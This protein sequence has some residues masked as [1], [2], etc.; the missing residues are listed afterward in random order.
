MSVAAP[1]V[2]TQAP[3]PGVPLGGA[4]RLAE[5]LL[6]IPAVAVGA[7]AV[8][9]VD[10]ADTGQL[11]DGFWMWVA[12]GAA[13]ALVAHLA[14]RLLAPYSDPVLLPVTVALNGLGLAL[15][16][17]LDVAADERAKARGSAA[18]LSFAE[19]Q[20]VWSALG[21]VLFIGV[22]VVVRELRTLAR[23][24]YTAMLVGLVLLLLPLAP[25]I[26][27]N[28]NGARIWIRVGGLS[29]QPGEIAKLALIVFFAGYLVSKRDVL[30]LA[31]SRVLGIDMPRGRD[32]GPIVVAWLASL[33][34]LVFQ[35]DLGTSLLFFGLFVAML[36]VAT[37]RV[38]W[39]VIG[40]VLFLA[41]SFAAYLM[42]GH[43][44]ER[45]QVWLHPFAD[46]NGTGY[47][48]VQSLYGLADGSL[49]GSGIA[50]GH[51]DLVPYANSDFIIATAGEL[52]GIT[53][54]MAIITLYAI[55]VA[56]GLKASLQVRDPFGRLLAFGLAF[57]VGLQVFVVVGGVTRLI[58]LTGL[59]TPFL[60]QGGSSLVANWVLVGLLLRVS[61]TARRPVPAVPLGGPV[62]VQPPTPPP[63]DAETQVIR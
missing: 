61:D 1:P 29:F 26:G 13:A 59:T 6:L 42:F 55:L 25:H 43:V 2:P 28:I 3:A 7:G 39:L 54:L 23:L 20:V 32:L 56:R 40:A 50:Q 60:S 48:I 16:H 17:R 31:R 5:L 37:E 33:G 19:H 45:V 36:Y 24:T 63:S 22:L 44:H 12:V 38:G 52:L 41:G 58:P 10:L 53:G 21:I 47:Q 46:A 15:I 27:R 57:A 14:V 4:G 34:V 8:A 11:P 9:Q 35:K 30:S 49:I 62:L 18:P 51:P